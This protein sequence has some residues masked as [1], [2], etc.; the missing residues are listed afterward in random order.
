LVSPEEKKEKMWTRA[1][2]E[3]GREPRGVL[4]GRRL[5]KGKKEEMSPQGS[6]DTPPQ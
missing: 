1:E 3:Y 2:H 5:E 4:N 6:I